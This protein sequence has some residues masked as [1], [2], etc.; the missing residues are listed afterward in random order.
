MMNKFVWGG[1]NDRNVNIDYNTGVQL[2]LYGQDSVM[3]DWQ[4]NWSVRENEKSRPVLDV[5]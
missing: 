5:A 3:P 1:A 2:Q 4:R